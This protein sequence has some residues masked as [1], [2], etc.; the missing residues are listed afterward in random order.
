MDSGMIKPL[1]KL[2]LPEYQFDVKINWLKIKQ[3]L[4][5][6]LGY[7]EKKGY[8]NTWNIVFPF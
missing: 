3:I 1:S 7:Q 4:L 8:F 5:I 2:K 6:E